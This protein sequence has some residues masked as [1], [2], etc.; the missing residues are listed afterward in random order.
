MS[1]HSQV[2]LPDRRV[3][4]ELGGR[5]GPGD[6]AFLEDDMSVGKLDQP[7]HV[8]VDHEDLLLAA[9]ELAAELPAPRVEAGEE[10]VDA[11]DA[12]GGAA[13]GAVAGPLEGAQVLVHRQV[14]EDLPPFGYEAD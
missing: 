11:A 14:G 7:L 12:H 6:A 4:V 1:S 10:L 9:G 13:A 3:G 8:L 5:A 2:T